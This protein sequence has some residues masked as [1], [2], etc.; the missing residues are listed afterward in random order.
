MAARALIEASRPGRR[1]LLVGRPELCR[2]SSCWRQSCSPRVGAAPSCPARSAD[3]RLGRPVARCSARGG[4]RRRRVGKTTLLAQWVSRSPRP[5]AWGGRRAR[6]RSGRPAH[7]RRGGAR[8][9]RRSTRVFRALAS[10]GAS[11]E[12][13][14]VPRLGAALAKISEELVLVLDD[15][16]TLENPACLD[17]IATV[18]SHVP[19]GSQLALARGGPAL[20]LGALRTRGLSGDRTGR[21]AY[22]RGGVARAS[23]CGRLGP[24]GRTG[25]GAVR[26]HGGLVG[27]SVPRRV[28][29]AGPGTSAEG[30][31]GIPGTTAGLGLP[32][33][34]AAGAPVSGGLPLPNA[35]RCPRALSGPLCDAVLET[36]GSA[37]SWSRWRTPTCSWCPWTQAGVV[38]LPPPVPG[39]AALGARSRRADLVQRLLER[40]ADW[41]VAHAQPETAIRYAQEA[42]DTARVAHLAEQCA[43]AAYESGRATTADRWLH[44]LEARGA[45]ER[46]AAVAVLGGLVATIWGG[47]PSR[48]LG[49]RGRARELRR[50]AARR[51]RLDRVVAGLPARAA[52]RRGWRGC[53]L[54]RSSRCGRWPARAPSA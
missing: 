10:P 48:A 38:P 28:V 23:G 52:L 21:A 33:V 42:G 18:A 12:G 24:T 32:A 13:T 5:F 19:V 53:A 2:R 34:G 1:L 54:M 31:G 17:A 27:R 51:Q 14:V 30:A 8:P 47:R 49:R 15:L 50:R 40:A 45:L 35:D 7:V 41:Y 11:V 46:N 37:A 20:P 44:W 29:D 3:R 26:A 6:Q 39:A 22:G 25:H 43:S 9:R 4:V 36:S 16:H